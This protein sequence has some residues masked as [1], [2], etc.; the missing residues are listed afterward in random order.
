VRTSL[1]VVATLAA[2][3]SSAAASKDGLRAR[4]S[5]APAS[6]ATRTW[7][8]SIRVTEGGRPVVARLVLSIRKGAERRAFRPRAIRRGLYRVRVVFPADGRWSWRVTAAGRTLARGAIAVSARITFDLPYDLAI[9]P[10]GK[11]FFLDRSRILL[12]DPTTSRLAVHVTTPS[13]ELIA[14]V[15]LGDGS[16]FVTDFPADRIL[17]VDPAGRVSAV[18][19]VQAPADL[20]ADVTGTTLWVASIAPGVGVVRVDV[21]SGRTQP[22]ADVENPHGIDRDAAG[23]FYVHDG[24]GISRIDGR[25]GIVSRFADVDGIKLL[26]APDN[27]VYGVVGDPSGGRVVRVEPDGEVTTVVGTGTIGPHRD[28]RALDAQI[29]PS[30]V[31][32]APD[33]SLLVAQVEPIAAIRRVDLAAGTIS[34][35]VRGR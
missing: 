14:M 24:H 32:L 18:A 17:R 22:F 3:C 26:A 30:A 19:S 10:D 25:T 8:P 23:D 4:V 29:L 2:A 21:A 34:T 33:G 6:L 15:R 16:F 9:A 12:F 1:L 13:R 35:V 11:I 20:V 31:Q 28:G 5:P 27:S 7:S